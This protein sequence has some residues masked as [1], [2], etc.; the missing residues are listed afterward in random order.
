[1]NSIR[2]GTL[3]RAG[4]VDGGREAAARVGGAAA[5]GAALATVDARVLEASPGAALFHPYIH[6]AGERGPFVNAAA[7][8]QFTGLSTRA[9][10]LDLVRSVYEGLGFAALD[11]YRTMGYVPEEI[12][13]AGGAAR[14]QAL[15][16]ILASVTGAPVRRS[17]RDEAGAAG[18]AMIAAV[19]IGAFPDMAAAARRWVAPTLQDAVAPDPALSALYGRLFP[20][21]RMAR[22]AMVPVWDGIARARAGTCSPAACCPGGDA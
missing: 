5:R 17:S 2:A 19:A 9:G 8:A 13:M 1:M 22:E 16:R 18:A 7:R 20:L 21:Y 11:C 4:F 6:E 3:N 15:R 14:S 10:Y 12:R